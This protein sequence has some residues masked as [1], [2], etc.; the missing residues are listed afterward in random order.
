MYSEGALRTSFLR[1]DIRDDLAREGGAAGGG[2]D[3]YGPFW[4]D[5]KDHVYG[6]T[7][8]HDATAAR[9]DANFR[10]RNLY[11]RLRDGFLLWW[12]DR[13]RW[14]NAPFEPIAPP[15]LYFPVPRLGVTVKIG[16]ILAVRDG[17]GSDHFVYPYWF[18][19]P[20]L[21]DEAARVGLWLLTLALPKTDP[22]ELRILDILRGR[23]FALDRNALLGD[24]SDLFARRY[25]AATAE[26]ERLRAEYD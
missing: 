20:A 19:R 14:T 11:P 15:G 17:R 24:E 6:Y 7:D 26:W 25:R 16:G 18:D 13:R 12:N 1:A 23:N 10:R 8:L 2:G 3:F 4:K 5:A 22:D 9:I 21:S